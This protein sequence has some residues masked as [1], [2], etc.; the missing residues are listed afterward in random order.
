MQ[1][2]LIRSKRRTLALHIT[3]EGGLEVRAPLRMPQKEIEDF[4]LLKQA[5]VEKH[6][7]RI[8]RSQPQPKSFTEGEEFY[9]LGERYKLVFADRDKPIIEL[10]GDLIIAARFRDKAERVIKYWFRDEAEE[11]LLSRVQAFARDMQLEPQAVRISNATQRWGSCSVNGTLNLSWRLVMAPL[12]IIDYVVVHEL[13]H[14]KQHNHSRA[15]WK[16]VAAVL[17]D[18]QY[19]RQWLKLNS[20]LLNL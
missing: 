4:I 20:H 12:E 14:M 18:Y 11:V 19:R 7:R 6:I 17:P 2:T 1:Y 15:F 3:P 5:W 13:A 10:N 9:Y 16:E 8:S